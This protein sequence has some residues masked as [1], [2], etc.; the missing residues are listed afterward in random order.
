VCVCVCVCV[1]VYLCVCLCER[2]HAR[3]LA[4]STPSTL[5]RTRQRAHRQ[6][7][8]MCGISS[9][10]HCVVTLAR[11]HAH[12]RVQSASSPSHTGTLTRHNV[13]SRVQSTTSCAAPS[14]AGTP[15]FSLS[16]AGCQGSKPKENTAGISRPPRAPA[17]VCD[18]GNHRRNG[19]L[20]S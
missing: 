17:D 18:A 4:F 9:Q 1:C 2:T 12:S 13:H 6:S 3:L 20:H 5:A 8:A 11:D 19:K 14:H 10:S 16:R 15:Q 7:H